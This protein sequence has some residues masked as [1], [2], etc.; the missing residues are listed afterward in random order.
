MSTSTTPDVAAKAPEK[1]VTSA[2]Q[3]E[4]LKTIMPYAVGILV[5]L[6]L[7]VL[8][9]VW[10]SNRSHYASWWVFALIATAGL[11]VLRWPNDGKQVFMESIWSN[12]LLVL[13]L[14]SGLIGVML[15]EPW[16]AACSVFMLIASLMARVIDRDTG[17]S[18]WT[19]SL[20]LFVSLAIPANYDV[21]LITWLQSTSAHLTSRILDLINLAHY[22]PG[23]VIQVP[24]K[25]Y[26]IE[27]ACSGIQ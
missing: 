24:G 20:P 25:K 1:K 19:V 13:G 18:I 21:R 6:P 4:I 23:T 2:D 26:G 9:Y 10:L 22:M 17:K 7:L 8:Y 3:S 27:E 12:I 11:A 5:Q 14:L 16:F 15:V